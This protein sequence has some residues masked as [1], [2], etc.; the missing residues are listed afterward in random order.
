MSTF[1]TIS[2]SARQHS[3]PFHEATV[4]DAMHTGVLTCPPETALVTVARMMASY[5]V[6]AIVVTLSDDEGDPTERGW[7]VVSD[8]DVTKAASM[9]HE[10]SSAGGMAQTELVTVAPDE[11][12]QRAAQLLTEHEVSH[13]VVADP[14][15]DRPLG[16]ISTLD[17]AAALAAR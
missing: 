3:P 17:I 14:E 4:A 8:S 2:S 6:H 13:L 15:R 10:D 9:G 7:A 16:V 1:Q 12:L 5:G 11:A